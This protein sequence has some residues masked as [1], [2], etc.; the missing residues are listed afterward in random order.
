MTTKNI[1]EDFQA[2]PLTLKDKIILITGAG[3]GIGKEAALTFAAFGATI[4]LLGRTLEKLE[5]VYDLIEEKGYP[6]AAIYPID[7]EG[8]TEKDYI[9]MCNVLDSNFQ[10]IDGILHNAAALGDRTALDNYCTDT[11]QRLLTVNV[12]APFILTQKLFPLL[13]RSTSASVVFTGSGVGRRG[14]A[15]WGAYAVTK[16]ATENLM[17]VFSDEQDGCNNIRFNSLNPGATH[18]PMRTAAYPAED[19]TTIAST[20]DI[21]PAYLYLM[22]DASEKESGQQFNAQAR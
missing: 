4:V 9:D 14:R 3:S 11:W 5:A 16:G 13:K 19:P 8:A 20:K 15:Y 2:A 12:T 21:M 10:R 17:Q 22:C 18:T 7:F 6:Q 1:P